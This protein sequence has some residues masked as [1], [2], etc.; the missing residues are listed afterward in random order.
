[1]K[2]RKNL[3]GRPRRAPGESAPAVAVRFTRAELE[4]YDRA[5]ARAGITR[6]EWFRRAL[7]SAVGDALEAPRGP[8]VTGDVMAAVSALLFAAPGIKSAETLVAQLAELLHRHGFK[9]K[10]RAEGRS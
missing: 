4:A 2:T 1:M 9:P 10:R 3:G 7:A 8:R 6:S 5:A